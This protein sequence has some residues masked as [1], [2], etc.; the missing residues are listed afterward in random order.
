M[1]KDGAGR[2]KINESAIG[3]SAKITIA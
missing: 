2:Y 1:A 3:W